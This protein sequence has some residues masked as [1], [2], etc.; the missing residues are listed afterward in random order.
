M[1]LEVK[2][3]HNKDLVHEKEMWTRSEKWILFMIH[4]PPPDV[5]ITITIN[6]FHT[7]I[8]IIFFLRF[9]FCLIFSFP[10]SLDTAA[11]FFKLCISSILLISSIP[12]AGI[13]S[14]MMSTTLLISGSCGD[15][16][17]KASMQSCPVILGTASWHST[18]VVT[19]AEVC[20][21]SRAR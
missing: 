12:L 14:C 20:V 15:E 16:E 17:R 2:N 21:K 10:P 4:C 19:E 7:Q 3:K 9:M 8:W 18:A 13:N 6:I 1:T 11:F 5:Q